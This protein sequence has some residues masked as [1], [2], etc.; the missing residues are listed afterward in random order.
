MTRKSGALEAADDDKLAAW[1]SI[2]TKGGEDGSPPPQPQRI[3]RSH[4]GL[5]RYLEDWIV[6]DVTLIG[7][8]YTLVG[9]QVSI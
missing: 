8:G 4:I 1:R 9:R 5:E 3:A 7:E 6:N 2:D